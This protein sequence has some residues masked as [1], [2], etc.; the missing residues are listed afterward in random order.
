MCV[1]NHCPAVLSHMTKQPRRHLSFPCG[2][3]KISVVLEG[4]DFRPTASFLVVT[5][6][7]QNDVKPNSL[8]TVIMMFQFD[9]IYF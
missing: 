6:L 1:W 5:L 4:V 2:K 8:W 7:V 3:L 9:L